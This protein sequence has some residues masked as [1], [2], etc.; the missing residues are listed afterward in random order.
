MPA[1]QD[2]LSPLYWPVQYRKYGRDPVTVG[3]P[4]GGGCMGSLSV[5]GQ[6][7]YRD[8]LSPQAAIS[9]QERSYHPLI[10]CSMCTIYVMHRH[11]NTSQMIYTDADAPI[12]W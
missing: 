7:D 1:I 5:V 8:I 12:S 9:S 4:E 10:V 3:A 6:F 2:I 11:M